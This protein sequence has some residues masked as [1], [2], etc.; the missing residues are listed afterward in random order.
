M[1]LTIPTNWSKDFLD[2]VDLS[3]VSEVY[4]K[5]PSDAVGGGRASAVFKSVSKA[6]ARDQI[7]AIR[8]RGIRF[9]YLLNATCMDNL[10]FTRAGR[11]R[12][13]ALLDWI[14]ES[15]ADSVT[16]A[17]PQLVALVK[18][19][20]PQLRVSVSTNVMVDN[21]ERVRYWE[22]F[23]VDQITLSYSDVNRDFAE[24]K[25]IADHAKCDIQLI[26]NLICRRHCP[27]QAA[28]SNFHSHASQS[29]HVNKR[30]PVDYCCLF[31]LI[32]IFSDP[33]EI[34]RSGWIRPEDLKAYEAIGIHRFKLVER[35]MNTADVVRIVG[36]YTARHYE[37]N[38]LDL[39]PSLGKY[40]YIT[41]PSLW[42]F[43]KH[44]FSFTKARPL[45]L[46]R[47]ASKLSALTRNKAFADSF[48]LYVDN[49]EL[50]GFIEHFRRQS[51]R[52]TVCE[53]C[54]Y[55]AAF[56]NKAIKTKGDPGE[57]QKILD[58]LTHFFDEL[59]TGSLFE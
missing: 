57:R 18:K 41:E 47:E 48:G 17:L 27:F 13:R 45:R 49:R 37:G 15:G 43:A 46:I 28:H 55:C 8:A 22:E 25:R 26:C 20:Y 19:Q 31:C 38:F 32:R 6:A 2:S 51:C 4:G 10:E 14:C 12:L 16:L 1:E 23:G 33:S 50:D 9:N 54:R 56:A 35:G 29:G 21:L 53:E 59:T 36:A 34:M 5:L 3:R 11:K 52:S 58:A 30:F 40:R 39:I 24:L 7:R 42:H 44:F